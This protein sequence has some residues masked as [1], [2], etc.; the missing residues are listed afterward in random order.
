MVPCTETML[1]SQVLTKLAWEHFQ[2]SERR[3]VSISMM[4]YTSRTMLTLL[5]YR[6]YS[7]GILVSMVMIARGRR[8]ETVERHRVSQSYVCHHAKAISSSS[9]S[10]LYSSFVS[11]SR[12]VMHL[13]CRR[14]WKQG[15]SA[16]GYKGRSWECICHTDFCSWTELFYVRFQFE[17]D[18]WLI[19]ITVAI[20]IYIYSGVCRYRYNR[21]T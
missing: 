9:R 13:M 2:F 15:G 5:L 16:A 3:S 17:I 7:V 6:R 1:W 20:Y 14:K 21:S 8:T 4:M 11:L 12:C 18:T 19:Y 10:L